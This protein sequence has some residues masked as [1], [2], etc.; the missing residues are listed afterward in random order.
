[1]I[2]F[3]YNTFTTHVQSL[4][5][6]ELL[7]IAVTIH[8]KSSKCPQILPMPSTFTDARMDTSE[9][10]LSWMDMHQHFTGETSLH[11]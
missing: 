1:M 8:D 11:F 4:I 3:L 2:I 9:H 7:L 6:A 5:T 10:G